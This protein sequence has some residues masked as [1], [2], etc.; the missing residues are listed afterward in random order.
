MGWPIIYHLEE[1]SQK[2]ALS[3]VFPLPNKPRGQFSL[4]EFSIGNRKLPLSE[5]SRWLYILLRIFFIA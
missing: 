1:R 2:S 5:L 4:S 3:L